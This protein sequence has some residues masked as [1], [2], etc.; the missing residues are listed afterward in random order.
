MTTFNLTNQN[1]ETNLEKILNRALQGYDLSPAETLLLLSPTTNPNLGKFALTQLPPEITA[2]QKT[3]DQLRQQQAGNT[4][5]YVINRNI[6]FT[7]ICEQHCSFCAFRRDDGK[8][9]AFWLDI[10]QILAKANDAC[11]LYTS[12]AADDW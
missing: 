10:N 12:D 2:I 7:N 4:V 9:G 1:L 11:L 6:N 3:A 8:T 5:T